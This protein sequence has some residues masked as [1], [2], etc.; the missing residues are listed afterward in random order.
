MAINKMKQQLKRQRTMANVANKIYRASKLGQK[1]QKVS[2]KS[3]NLTSKIPTL[4]DPAKRQK[5][6]Q[7]LERVNKRAI[8]RGE[9]AANRFSKKLAAK[10]ITRTPHS[11]GIT[12]Q[13]RREMQKNNPDLRANQANIASTKRGKTRGPVIDTP[14]GAGVKPTRPVRPKRDNKT[15][16]PV[17][18]ARRKPSERFNRGI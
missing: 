3:S 6:I 1:L 15:V 12:L 17:R 18:R 11:S 9:K 4:K 13:Q 8:K 7:R 14:G 16:T 10:G 5:A 2:R